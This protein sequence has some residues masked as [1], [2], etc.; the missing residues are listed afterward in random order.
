MYCIARLKAV[1]CA[2]TESDPHELI[3]QAWAKRSVMNSGMDPENLGPSTG[4]D[5]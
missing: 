3:E 5:T 2:G 1:I 4:M